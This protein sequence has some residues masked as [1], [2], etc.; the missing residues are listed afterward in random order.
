MD[1]ERAD[2]K[3]VAAAA[4]AWGVPVAPVAADAPLTAAEAAAP[5]H[6]PIFATGIDILALNHLFCVWVIELCIGYVLAPQTAC[7]F[8]H[9]AGHI[10]AAVG[11]ITQ[12]AVFADWRRVLHV[13]VEVAARVVRW[14]FTPRVDAA[15]GAARGLLP[16][17]FGGQLNRPAG[18]LRQPRAEGRRVVPTYAR[19]GVILLLADVA[20]RPARMLP[21]CAFGVLPLLAIPDVGAALFL[22]GGLVVCRLGKGGELRDGDRVF[23]DVELVEETVCCGNSSS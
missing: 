23:A 2:T 19:H 3:T 4:T 5:Q 12:R 15:I 17:R 7:P 1:G 16:L 6:A 13:H 10:R 8:P 14:F 22:C 21:V 20:F 11:A 9:I 18:C